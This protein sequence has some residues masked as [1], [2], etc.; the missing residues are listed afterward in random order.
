MVPDN[1]F[2]F[3]LTQELLRNFLFPIST[4]ICV[5]PSMGVSNYHTSFCVDGFSRFRDMRVDENVHLGV[6]EV[7]K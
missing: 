5:Y 4:K 1:C 3:S 2:S 7:Q 6:G